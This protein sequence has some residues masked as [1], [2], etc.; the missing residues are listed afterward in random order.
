MGR[1]PS[2][3]LNLPTRMRAIRQRSG[4]VFYYY[5]AGGKPRKLR[6][7]GSDYVMAVQQW[8]KLH[9]SPAPIKATVGDAIARYLASPKF[10]GLGTGT[11]DDYKYAIDK[12]MEYFGPAPL[13]EVRPSHLVTYLEK[14]TTGDGKLRASKHRAQREVQILGMIFRYAR[15]KDMT[16]NDPKESVELDKLPGR[17]NIYIYDEMLDAVYEKSPPDL[18]DAIDLAY[19]IGQRPVD[20]LAMAIINIRDGMLEYRQR[21]TG[22]PQRVALMPGLAD[23]LKRIEARKAEIAAA[24]AK[25]PKRASTVYTMALLV[26][27]RGQKMTKAKLR[28]RFEAARTA[29]NIAGADFQFRDLRR[30][31]GSDLRDQDG[32]DAAQDLLGHAQQSQTEHYTGGR[33]KKIT[34]LPTRNAK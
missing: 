8:A 7:L 21:K 12:I 17:K 5:D 26:D 6:P 10:I 29:A 22:M 9:S 14:R 28:S 13:D 30:K 33:G 19:Y 25:K 2:V 23:L 32:L 18:C 16:K 34:K 11:Q 4:R 31:S 27:E 20:L 24:N 15:S 3:N 1:K